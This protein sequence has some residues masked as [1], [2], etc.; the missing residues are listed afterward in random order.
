M[1]C[2]LYGMDYLHKKGLLHRDIKPG[3]VL[4]KGTVYKLG[5]FGF[6]SRLN[7][8]GDVTTNCGTPYDFFLFLFNLCFFF[9]FVY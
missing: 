2:M 5:D 7:V 6:M 8:T 4:Q 3:N 9:Y 1:L